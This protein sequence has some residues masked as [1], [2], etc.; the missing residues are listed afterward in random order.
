MS[1]IVFVAVIIVGLL[2]SI[3]FGYC[4]GTGDTNNPYQICSA[5]DLLTMAADTNDYNKCFILTAD[6]NLQGQVFTTAII[7]PDTVA[8][9]YSFEGTA[10]T[11][12]FDGNDHKITNFTINGGSNSYLG[13]FGY[14]NSGSV[15]NLGLENCSVS[16][17]SYDVGGLVGDNSGNISNCYSTGAVSG[18]FWVSA[19]WW[20]EAAAISA[21]AIR[22]VRSAV[23]VLNSAVWWE[24]AT[25]ISAIAI[26]RV[27]LAVVLILLFSAVWWDTMKATA[28]SATAIRRVRSAV[29]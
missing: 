14:I 8:G 26:R 10:F 22:R 17:D 27:R 12:T 11:G 23:L 7:A 15:K 2:S 21:I 18:P 25:A 16:C 28:V 5:G 1:R 20:E 3:S 24:E 19:G 29:F 9:D 13:L 6:V 4:G